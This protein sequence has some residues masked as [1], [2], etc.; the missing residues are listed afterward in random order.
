MKK[1]NFIKGLIMAVVAFIASTLSDQLSTG[2]IN[3]IYVGITSV[4]IVITYLAKNAF[5]QSKSPLGS[6]DWRDLLSGLLMAI[7]TAISAYSAQLITIGHLD[8]KALVIAIV[9]A[10]CGYFAKTLGSNSQGQ[11]LKKDN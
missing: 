5:I 3:W 9:S 7:G 2:P 10:V 6:A 11:V 1:E 8:T 4:G